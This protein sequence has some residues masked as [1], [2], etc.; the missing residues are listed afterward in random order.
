[1]IANA[2]ANARMRRRRR[3]LAA[4]FM[5]VAPTTPYANCIDSKLKSLATA[6]VP[7]RRGSSSFSSVSLVRLYTQAAYTE[8]VA[9]CAP[10][11]SQA[12]CHAKAADNEALFGHPSDRRRPLS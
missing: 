7:W 12:A 1:M 5:L 11:S 9:T 3:H 2:I 6:G 8:L 10:L 4:A